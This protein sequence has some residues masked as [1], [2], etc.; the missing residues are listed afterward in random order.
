MYVEHHDLDHEFP[1]L[2]NVMEDLKTRNDTF[3]TLFDEYNRLTDE[4]ERLEELDLP[5]DD[6]TI[7]NMKKK[8]VRLKDQIYHI[9]I[10]YQA[11]RAS[12]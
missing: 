11:G 1:K 10:G 2:H 12:S 3:R 4:I 5:V 8:R 6:F 9:V 7:E